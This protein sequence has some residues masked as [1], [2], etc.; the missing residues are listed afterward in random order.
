MRRR[1]FIRLVGLSPV[2][3]ML[4]F[5]Q[6]SGKIPKIGVL[7]HAGSAELEKPFLDALTKAFSDLG[8]VE[9]RNVVFVHRY[10]ADKPER[11]HEL[12]KDLIDSK[13]DVIV[14]ETQP[15]AV[16]LKQAASKIP[17]VFITVPDPVGAGLIESLAHPGGNLTGLSTAAGDIAGK[18][19]DLFKEAVPTL[20]R[21]ALLVDPSD[22]LSVAYK[23][24]YLNAAK[25]PRLELD[26]VEVPTPDAIEDA[27]SAIAR[28][29]Y[30]GA[31]ITG[32]MMFDNRALVGASILAHKLPTIGGA[33][34]AVPSG[35]LLSYGPDFLDY[36]R[37]AAVYVD[38]ILKGAK[39]ADLPVEQP[40][41]LKLVINLRVARA[42]GL[43]MPPTLLMA[44]DEI[45]E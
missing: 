6:Q 8:Y 22:S 44:A 24:A 7:W 19:L 36:Q 5:A 40:T 25:S 32:T 16:A 14:A 13:V 12:A 33:A 35:L 20:G 43:A 26:V 4:A 31:I 3:P 10:P 9:G 15:G 29:R 37:M 11:Y 2:W 42:L 21:V 45:I 1:E 17:V 23:S 39:P 18:R 38:K 28:D 34:E 30:D 27:F 41:R